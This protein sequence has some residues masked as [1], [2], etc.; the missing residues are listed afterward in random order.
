MNTKKINLI[1]QPDGISCGPSCLKM[2]SNHYN[3][4]V[5]MDELKI[6]CGTDYLSGTTDIKMIKGLN[7]LG[8]NWDK[9]DCNKINSYSRLDK[10]FVDKNIVLFR[11]LVHGVKHWIICDT[12][13]SKY[14]IYDPWLGEYTINQTKLEE[15]W[16]PRNYDGFVINGLSENTISPVISKILPN[17]IDEII[18][19]ASL[20][21]TNVMSYEMNRGYI[22]NSD[23]DFDNSVKLTINNEIIGC[24]LIKPSNISKKEYGKG[25]QGFALAIKPSFRNY[26]YGNLLKEWFEKWA[27]DNKYN[28]IWGQHLKGLGNKEMWL[29]RRDIYSDNGEI[30]TTIKRF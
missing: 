21:F 4:K 19:M 9:F 20:V 28:Y 14:Y 23:V 12:R 24:Y 10:A 11:T 5:T 15:I 6:V 16:S 29:K 25:C 2:I 8:L 3:I 17:E 22:S 18:N 27:I 30:F 13:Y 1:K 26:G 7:Y